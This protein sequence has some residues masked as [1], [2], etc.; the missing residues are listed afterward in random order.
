MDTYTLTITP[1][2]QEQLHTAADMVDTVLLNLNLSETPYFGETL[3]DVRDLL[4]QL[5]NNTLITEDQ[6]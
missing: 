3:G 6:A 1:N 5:A 4:V 2:L